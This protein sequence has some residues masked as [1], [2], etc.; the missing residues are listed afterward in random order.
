MSF[1]SQRKKI[2]PNY[3][4]DFI[5]EDYGIEIEEEIGSDDENWE[6]ND[7]TSDF[8]DEEDETDEVIILHE[9]F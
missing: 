9:I 7:E 4:T 8:E 2:K 1:Y 6:E 5:T 3:L